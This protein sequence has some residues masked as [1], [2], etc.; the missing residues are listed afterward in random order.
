MSMSESRV[1]GTRAPVS[2]SVGG[3]IK[4]D[5]SSPRNT[6]ITEITVASSA[7]VS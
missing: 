3:G 7:L 4:N 5:L 6:S 1:K 2:A